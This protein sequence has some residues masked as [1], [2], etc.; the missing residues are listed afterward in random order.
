MKKLIAIIL[1]F[2]IALTV[3]IPA[4]ASEDEIFIPDITQE[5]I[6][7]SSDVE[8]GEENG[9]LPAIEDNEPLTDE[10]IEEIRKEEA[11]SAFDDL[12]DSATEALLGTLM[13]PLVPVMLIV[14]VFGW[15]TSATAL[16]SPLVLISLPFQFLVACAEAIDIYVNFNASEYQTVL[17]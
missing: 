14:P 16:L 12:R 4:F 2:T 11:L 15:V 3:G 7:D 1:S 6:D 13:L 10:E 9:D 17:A 8:E 5:E